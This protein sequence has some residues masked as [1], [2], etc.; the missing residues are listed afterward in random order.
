MEGLI[1][2][3]IF[4]VLLVSGYIVGK[5]REK[6]HLQSLR[7]RER[8]VLS[9]PIA[10]VKKLSQNYKE[11]TLVSGSVVIGQD[12]FKMVMSNLRNIFGGQLNSYETL[13][14]R[15]R[16]EAILR[17]KEQAI[18]WGAQ[19]IG[20]LKVETSSISSGAK[21]QS[22]ACEVLVYATAGKN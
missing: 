5:S 21:K 22:G 6:K 20:N 3:G 17:M 9:L 16:R 19:E 4:A 11:V 15:G 1:Q 14:N 8:N 12:Y 13:L 2:L 10:S 18:Q 7:K